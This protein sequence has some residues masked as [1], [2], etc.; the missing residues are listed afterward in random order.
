MQKREKIIVIITIIAALYAL[1]DFR[2]SR[3]KN[4]TGTPPI[5]ESAALTG[6]S[7]RLAAINSPNNKRFKTLVN[8]INKPWSNNIFAGKTP[9][10]DTS[11]KEERQKTIYEKL[12]ATINKFIYSGYLKMGDE[13][14]AIINDNNY[15]EGEMIDGFLLRKINPATAQLSRQGLNF[16]LTARTLPTNKTSTATKL[17]K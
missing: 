9:D 5:M 11:T 14:I 4:K 10:K 17:K 6:I 13:K 3:H 1:I 16:T 12:S 15:R 7:A 2:L 8:R